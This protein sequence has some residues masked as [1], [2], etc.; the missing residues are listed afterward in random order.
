MM[1]HKKLNTII[2]YN[3]SKLW[4][5]YIHYPQINIWFI[6]EIPTTLF[7]C[8]KII[9]I[10]F[11]YVLGKYLINCIVNSLFHPFSYNH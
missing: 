5:I 1:T 2:L 4:T 6:V 7:N 10:L 11:K 8:H 3:A 9:V